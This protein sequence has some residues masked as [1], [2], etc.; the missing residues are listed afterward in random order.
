MS[1][2]NGDIVDV[3]NRGIIV[4]IKV[5]YDFFFFEFMSIVYWVLKYVFVIM[6]FEFVQ[7][8][9]VMVVILCNDIMCI[10]V[11]F[12]YKGVV[13]EIESIEY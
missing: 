4:I 9:G 7:V 13:C 10:E 3:V 11:F 6:Q 12:V 8:N 1:V 5:F 2:L